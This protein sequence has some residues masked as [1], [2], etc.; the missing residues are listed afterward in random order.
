M[1]T[2]NKQLIYIYWL[3]AL[4]ILKNI[5][6]W[7]G[8]SHISWKIENVWNHQPARHS[9][10]VQ[11]GALYYWWIIKKVKASTSI[12]ICT[13]KYIIVNRS[14]STWVPPNVT[15]KTNLEVVW[16][17]GFSISMLIG[18]YMKGWSTGMESPC[19]ISPLLS[20]PGTETA[21]SLEDLKVHL[22]G[23]ERRWT[24]TRNH[25]PQEHIL[26]M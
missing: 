5:S 13:L 15:Q 16:N 3:V 22:H 4:T 14:K 26:R 9:R 19:P 8:L 25:S 2:N 11:T 18:R 12:V 23:V 10:Q 17:C 7:E 1:Y 21:G 6:Q 20:F 24:A